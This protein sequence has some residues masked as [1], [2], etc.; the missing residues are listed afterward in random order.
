ME[1]KCQ[2]DERFCPGD[3]CNLHPVFHEKRDQGE[4]EHRE[5]EE[6]SEGIL[7]HE[8]LEGVIEKEKKKEEEVV[9][10]RFLRQPS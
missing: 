10:D 3:E 2:G 7:S 1:K 4:D 9:F 8:C 6:E 5:N